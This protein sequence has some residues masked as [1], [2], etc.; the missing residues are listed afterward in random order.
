MTRVNVDQFVLGSRKK[1]FL[2][3]LKRRHRWAFLLNRVQWYLYSKTRYV[4]KFP[5]HVDY[6]ASSLCNMKCP[7]CFRPYRADQNDGNMDFEMFCKSIDE[8]VR[9]GLYSIRVSWRGESTM[10][11]KFI[12]MIKYAK[13]AGIKEVSTLSNGLKIQGEYAED[14]VRS[15]I[16]YIS[17]SIDGL[18]ENYNKIRKPARF[19]DTIHR[20]QNI[21]WL[22]DAIGNGYPRL[23][24]NTIWSQIKRSAEEYYEI[25][26]PIADII[27]FNPD[28]DY[29]EEASSVPSGHVCQYPYQ[30][31]SVKWNGD[32][33]LCIS[34]WDG[35]VILGNIREESL[36][37]IW[38]SDRMQQFRK[39]QAVGKI[40]NYTPCTKCHRA[41][42]EQVGSKRM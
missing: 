21:R 24:V 23:K 11:P 42:T 18:H 22:R 36:Q 30:R 33:P 20:L 37:E 28:Y 14:L 13:K 6:E 9:H 19:D 15:G 39:D 40:R 8:C 29:A 16:D 35:E 10:N 3:N 26:N 4:P 5:I 25:F 34:D 38:L 32:V 1:E 17:V 7:M 31:L 12:E 2:W 27:S 41:V